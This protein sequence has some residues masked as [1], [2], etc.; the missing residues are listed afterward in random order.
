MA[1]S[2]VLLPLPLARAAR[3]IRQA[4][5]LRETSL[6]TGAAWYRFVT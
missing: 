6:T 2:S 3:G 4:W 5:M 1:R